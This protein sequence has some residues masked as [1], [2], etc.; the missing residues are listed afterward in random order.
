MLRYYE[1]GAII[2]NKNPTHLSVFEFS[3]KAFSVF[4]DQFNN[5]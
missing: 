2:D 5:D 4:L 3:I 1:L